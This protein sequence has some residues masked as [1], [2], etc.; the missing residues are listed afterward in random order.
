MPARATDGTRLAKLVKMAIPIC[1]QAQR[2]Y[3]RT[4][5]GRLPNFEDWKIAVLIMAAILK[6]RKSKSAQYSFL[7]EH[8]RKFKRWLGLDR[9]PARSTYFGR[10]HQAHQIFK[11][12]IGLQGKKAIKE[13]LAAATTVA[14]DKSLLG[15]HGPLWQQKRTGTMDTR[16]SII[17]GQPQLTN[18]RRFLIAVIALRFPKGV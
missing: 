11:V 18:Y 15:A 17:S 6:R 3:P 1:E 8:H 4:G 13:G 16:Y 2:Q 10:Y 12:A 7:H 14:V 5:S 9:F